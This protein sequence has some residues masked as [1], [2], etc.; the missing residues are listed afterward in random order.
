MEI[1]TKL[2]LTDEVFCRMVTKTKMLFS[3]VLG[4]AGELH[5]EKILNEKKI[6]FIKVETDK[7]YDY[8]VDNK[9]IQIKR[10]ET[11]STNE[12]FL[13]VNL[14][15]THGDRS[16]KG[17][18]YKKTDFDELVIFDV[19]FN[20]YKNIST[21]QITTNKKFND[22]LEGRYKIKRT[23]KDLLSKDELDFLESFKQKNKL[24]PDAIENFRNRLK[25]SYVELLEYS[26]S[27]DK[28]EIDSLFS[29]DNFRLVVGAKGFAAEEH[30]NVL[31]DKNNI[32]YT[33]DK[34]M[35]SKV[36][37]WVNNKIRIQV[38]I[39]H[40]KSVDHNKWAFKTHKSHGA[41]EK[42]LYK[43]NEFDYVALFI[44]FKMDETKDKYLP[45]DV[46]NEFIIIPMTDLD[47]HPDYPG[48]LKRVSKFD[49]KKYMVNDLSLINK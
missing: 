41:K 21:K 16:G 44:G 18:F 8:L 30:F 23:N 20:K 48:H 42:E 43:K 13:G 37:H 35:Y 32:P 25:L 31:L 15:Q 6:K 27:L 29:I 45:V 26:C 9:K 17:N 12:K 19:L 24:F 34:D 33:Q 49:K 28:N 47:E 40:L 39:P 3:N 46:S 11:A 22:C 36:D 14:T 5:Y 38:K 1:A 2:G 4:H 10:F 7:H